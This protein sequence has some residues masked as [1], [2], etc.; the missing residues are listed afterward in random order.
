MH[1]CREQ[2]VT[3]AENYKVVINLLNEIETTTYTSSSSSTLEGDAHLASSLEDLVGCFDQKVN[4]VL[5]DLGEN[6]NQMAPVQIRTQ[7]EIMSESQ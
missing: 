2:I 7:D 6:T 4:Q 1:F 3:R 5:K